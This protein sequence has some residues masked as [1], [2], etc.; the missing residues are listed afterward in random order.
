MDA[1]RAALARDDLDDAGRK[2]IETYMNK[3]N[4]P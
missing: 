4:Q 1:Y 3:L 2:M